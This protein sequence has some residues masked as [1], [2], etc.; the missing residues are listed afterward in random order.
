LYTLLLFFVDSD[1]RAF[2]SGCP[3][4]CSYIIHH[5]FRSTFVRL[6]AIIYP[7]INIHDVFEAVNVTYFAAVRVGFTSISQISAT[8]DGRRYPVSTLTCYVTVPGPGT[9]F[10]VSLTSFAKIP[11][12]QNDE[13]T[14]FSH[15]TC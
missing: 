14:C 2:I 5:L 8:K 6:N 3:L 10:M 13:S 12:S 7:L 9:F 4:I 15:N 11:A 1:G